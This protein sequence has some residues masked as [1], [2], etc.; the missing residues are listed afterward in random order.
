MKLLE[1]IN[2]NNTEPKGYTIRKVVRCVI[3]DE[4][5]KKVLFFGSLLVGGG[6]E[7]N[8]SDEDAVIREA[9]EEVGAQVEIIKPIGEVI[10]YRDFIKRKYIVHGYLCRQIGSLGNP[11]TKDPEEQ[12]TKANWIDIN[13]AINKLE[14]EIDS[15]VKQYS[16]VTA[17]DDNIQ[18]RTHN[19]R[20]SLALLKEVL[21]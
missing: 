18:K 1:T 2:E 15:L 21:N 10:A 6:V 14:T 9:I 19:R 12:K 11:T 20:V 7:E 5:N 3:F 17:Q 13:A 8:E 4:S 16:A